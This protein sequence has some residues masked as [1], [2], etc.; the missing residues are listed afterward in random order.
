MNDI[1]DF[2]IFPIQYYF[3][4]LFFKIYANTLIIQMVLDQPRGPI[5][6]LADGEVVHKSRCRRERSDGTRRNSAPQC[7]LLEN[8]ST[9]RD[10]NT[11][12]GTW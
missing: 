8:D 11:S 12:P 10:H 1:F 5:W 9:L 2:D 6:R 7:R 3:V 4:I